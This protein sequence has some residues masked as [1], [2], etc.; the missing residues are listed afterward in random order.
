MF[1]RNKITLWA[2]SVFAVALVWNEPQS[3]AAN[4]NRRAVRQRV[5]IKRPYNRTLKP[6]TE[7]HLITLNATG[8]VNQSQYKDLRNASVELLRRY[9]PENHCPGILA[10]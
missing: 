3:N 8:L 10:C 2:L 9:H 5:P 7:G 1:C 4:P 6:I